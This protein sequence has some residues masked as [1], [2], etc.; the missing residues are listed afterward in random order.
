MRVFAQSL[1][2]NSHIPSQAGQHEA[3]HCQVDHGFARLSLAFVIAIERAV[4]AEPA[5]GARDRP[6]ARQHLEGVQFVSPR[7]D[8]GQ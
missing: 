7:G 1:F 6:A 4:A 8:A 3:N 5:G 2:D